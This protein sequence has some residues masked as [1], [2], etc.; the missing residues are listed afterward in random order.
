MKSSNLALPYNSLK[1]YLKQKYSTRVQKLTVSLATTCPNIDGTKSVGGCIY[2]SIGSRPKSVNPYL[3]LEEQI[4]SQIERYT[5]RFGESVL[6]FVYFQSYSNTYLELSKLERALE[7]ASSFQRVVGIDI[8]TRPDCVP[9]SALEL[10]SSYAKRG[11][12]VWLELG[13]QSANFST[14]RYINRAHGVSDFVDAVLRARRYDIKLCA[15]LILGL[16][17]EDK[18]DMIESAKLISALDLDGVKIHPI[19]VI[20]NTPLEKLYEEGKFRPLELEEYASIVASIIEILPPRMI[21]H[22]LTG[23]VEPDRLVAP[24]YCTSEHKNSVINAIL[25]ELELRSI[26]QGSKSA[27]SV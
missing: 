17:G 13:L 21:I 26:T 5:K 16:P 2:C 18:Q 3:S 24:Y 22:R 7:I 20:K 25:K 4:S 19:H 11:F 12:E 14:L 8:S 15:H 27:F 6:F 10:I 9:E 1:D 23:E